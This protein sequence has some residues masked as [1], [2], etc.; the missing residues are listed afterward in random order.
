MVSFYAKICTNLTP[1][2][3]EYDK[4]AHMTPKVLGTNAVAWERWIFTFAGK[5]QLGVR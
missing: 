1:F 5:S 4:A 2:L 3:G